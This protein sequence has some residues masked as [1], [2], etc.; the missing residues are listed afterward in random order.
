M[1]TN[2]LP[3]TEAEPT[4]L[5]NRHRFGTDSCVTG[6][7]KKHFH[8]GNLQQVRLSRTCLETTTDQSPIDAIASIGF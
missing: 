8:L 2:I 5:T 7:T 1:V 4:I 3:F 6:K